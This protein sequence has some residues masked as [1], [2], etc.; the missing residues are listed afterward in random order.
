MLT[1]SIFGRDMFDD[2]LG[3][4][5]YDGKDLKKIEKKLYGGRDK[6]LMKTDVKEQERSYELEMD[7]PGFEK[8]DVKVSLENGY[9][10]VSAEKEEGEE[11]ESG[12]YIRR[13]RCFGKCQRTFYVGEEVGQ[14]DIKGAFKHGILKLSIPKKEQKPAV[15]EKRYIAIEG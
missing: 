7:L 9:L 1:S 15:E 8:D 2:F 12:K 3:F 14:E 10:T 5:F 13:E 6:N 11:K 4:P